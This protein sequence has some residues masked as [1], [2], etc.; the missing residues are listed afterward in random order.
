MW[1]I[2]GEG[3]LTGPDVADDDAELLT[4]FGNEDTGPLA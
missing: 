3:P 4:I 2:F 1:N